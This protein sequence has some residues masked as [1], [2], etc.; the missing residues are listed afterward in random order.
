[1]FPE[2]RF[3]PAPTPDFRL[4]DRL[5]DKWVDVHAGWFLRPAIVGLGGRTVEL[6]VS[7]KLIA[8]VADIYLLNREILLN[9]EGFAEKKVTNLLEA[10]DLS[11]RNPLHRI[12]IG[13]G[14]RGVGEVAANDLARKY[15]DLDQL[16]KATKEDIK[17]IEGFGPN[18]AQAIVDW[19]SVP[20]NLKILEKV[21][22]QLLLH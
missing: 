15:F 22:H 9:L 6:L 7:E 2:E 5:K 12:I 16:S 8:D 18:T 4:E 21:L 19:F 13:L 10:I 17:E 3:Q 11:K 1:M 14:I 20:A